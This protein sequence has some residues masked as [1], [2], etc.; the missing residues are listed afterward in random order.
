MSVIPC[1]ARS[2]PGAMPDLIQTGRSG[3]LNPTG[4][5]DQ[6][7][8]KGACP[9]Q[10]KLLFRQIR[11][12]QF[13]GV[14]KLPGRNLNALSAPGIPA[15][16]VWRTKLTPRTI[17]CGELGRAD[18]PITSLLPGHNMEMEVR[19]L[20]SAK[21]PV[22]LKR[23]N[24]ERPIGLDECFRYSLR[25][26]HYGSA[27]LVG[28]VE[29]RCDMS[30]CDNATLADFELPRIHYGERMFAFVDDRP[31]FFA[32]SHPFTQVAWVS[33]RKFD[34]RVSPI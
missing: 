3:V 17:E 22:V 15:R 29:Q 10:Q 7:R 21:D 26:G 8:P 30:A 32:T 27:L 2:R 34:Q 19:S 18:A 13:R 33:C 25:C 4:V 9:H 23:E 11:T 20:L 31:S 5:P 28:K 6:L 14:S 12:N 24:S 1:K 16:V